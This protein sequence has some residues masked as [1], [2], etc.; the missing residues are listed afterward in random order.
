MQMPVR[1][2]GN[3]SFCVLL[4]RFFFFFFFKSALCQCCQHQSALCLN[5]VF[6]ST[7]H[8]K[9]IISGWRV[10]WSRLVTGDLTAALLSVMTLLTKHEYGSEGVGGVDFFSAIVTVES[11][12][13]MFLIM[14]LLSLSV[15]KDNSN[16]TAA[17]LSLQRRCANAPISNYRQASHQRYSHTVPVVKAM[18][19]QT[20]K[21]SSQSLAP[22]LQ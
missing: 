19:K 14:I 12:L 1:H 13:Q 2:C 5:T 8:T 20:H 3:V 18:N 17:I 21:Q 6:V 10:I 9:L 7:W 11:P 15:W 4:I 22:E 16:N